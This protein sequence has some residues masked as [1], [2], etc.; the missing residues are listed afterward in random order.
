MLTLSLQAVRLQSQML[1][2]CYGRV[3]EDTAKE[4]PL[5]ASEHRGWKHWFSP[6][7]PVEPWDAGSEVPGRCR[8]GQCAREAT[9]CASAKG[10][11]VLGEAGGHS[12]SQ[13]PRGGTTGRRPCGRRP[14][15]PRPQHK[16]AW[17]DR[18]RLCRSCG[19]TRD[20]L[21]APLTYPGVAANVLSSLAADCKWEFRAQRVWFKPGRQCGLCPGSWGTLTPG[22]PSCRVCRLRDGD[23]PLTGRN[24]SH[25]RG[26]SLRCRVREGSWQR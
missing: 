3:N 23:Q 18:A 13:R 1:L 8:W 5:G 6:R 26:G 20:A 11:H 15:A 21:A 24:L 9:G 2:S 10:G 12:L 14:E 4:G 7:G 22:R 25:E 16:P 17:P 19:R